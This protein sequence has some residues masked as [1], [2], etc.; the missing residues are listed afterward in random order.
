MSGT[1]A[2]GATVDAEAIGAIGGAPGTATTTADSSSGDWS[3]SVPAGFGSTTI[4]VTAT[5]GDSTG[6]GQLTVTNVALPGTT[7]LNVTDPT[8]DDN[9]PGHLRLPDRARTSTPGAFDLT[10]MKVAETST[11]VYIQV[12]LANMDSTFGNS[13]GAQLL[14]VYVHDP[15]AGS[16]ST[17][18]IDPGRNY[19]IAPSDAWSELLEAQGFRSP[20]W[21]DANNNSLGSAQFVVDQPS[22]TATL[23]MPVARLWDGRLEL[24]VHGRADRPGRLQLQTR[25]APS[26]QRPG[27]FSFGVCPARRHEPDLRRRSQH[28]AQGDGHD[29]AARRHAEQRARPDAWAGRAA[30]RRG[31]L[32][33]QSARTA[34][35][36][37]TGQPR[38]G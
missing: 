8:G 18:A 24:G 1:T 7:V 22:K 6:Y 35:G 28:G 31:S 11:D 29:H 37:R 33:S 27:A 26:R 4:T 14:D 32:I 15:S 12:S 34:A 25:L 16:T 3:L 5:K 17:A 9:G 23:I 10:G 20:V 2:P 21:V 36:L 13:F 30:G 38:A 19:T